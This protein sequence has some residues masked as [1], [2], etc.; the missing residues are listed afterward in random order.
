MKRIYQ[1]FM[2]AIGSVVC[3][4]SVHGYHKFCS[5]NH[6]YS[7]KDKAYKM[8]F[9]TVIEKSAPSKKPDFTYSCCDNTMQ[10]YVRLSERDKKRVKK[11][12]AHYKPSAP[13]TDQMI[14]RFLEQR[15][16]RAQIV[17]WVLQDFVKF[18]PEATV[19]QVLAA[20]H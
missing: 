5:V 2:V 18:N 3:I 1:L 15:R 4:G 17:G 10:C 14:Q 11:W 9:A 6:Q 19:A 12:L 20:L 16:V 7:V 13:V 8:P